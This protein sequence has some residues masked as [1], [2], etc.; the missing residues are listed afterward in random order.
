M[1][2]TWHPSTSPVYLNTS[3][4]YP[5]LRCQGPRTG[6]GKADDD[7][8]ADGDLL[9]AV[10]PTG[11]G[12]WWR[13]D[14]RRHGEHLKDSQQRRTVG[15]CAVCFDFE[16]GFD[17]LA[18][19]RSSTA[20]TTPMMLFVIY[21]ASICIHIYAISYTINLKQPPHYTTTHIRLL[22]APPEAHRPF[23]SPATGM[24]SPATDAPAPKLS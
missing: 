8:P 12:T 10:A 5:T 7:V 16:Y 1:K 6:D 19:L 15:G 17:C 3:P 14:R 11:D 13:A 2:L 20:A 18:G 21:T 24:S 9:A 23:T 22:Y 4:V